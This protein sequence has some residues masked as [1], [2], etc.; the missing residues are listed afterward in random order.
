MAL[1]CNRVER[2]PIQ[3]FMRSDTWG[4]SPGGGMIEQG[5]YDH[6]MPKFTILLYEI[7]TIVDKNGQVF[8]KVVDTW[9]YDEATRAPLK[10]VK[11]TY[12]LV[13]LPRV[14]HRASLVKVQLDDTVYL[15]EGFIIGNADTMSER[16]T[17][18]GYVIYDQL[19]T[20]MELTADQ[21]AA[22]HEKGIEALPKGY[23]LSI[24]RQLIPDSAKDWHSAT[25]NAAVVQKT[26][27][28]QITLWRDPI[29][30][31]EKR[32]TED[33]QKI[34]TITMKKDC[35]R[36]T[37]P[38]F[39]RSEKLKDPM[40]L[41]F[42]IAIDA[43]EFEAKS[44]AALGVKCEMRKGGCKLETVDRFGATMVQRVKPQKYVVYRKTV[45]L[46]NRA[47]ST[48]QFGIWLT[49]PGGEKGIGIEN[50]AVKDYTGAT[51]S[52]LPA[53]VSYTEPDDPSPKP[54]YGWE[55]VGETEPV[56]TQTDLDPHGTLYDGTVEDGGVYEY[57]AL[58][59]VGTSES[60]E[61]PHRTVTYSGPLTNTSGVQ[62]KVI[63]PDDGPAAVVDIT[64]PVLDGVPDGYG[65]TV[66]IMLPVAPTSV[67]DLKQIGE[68]VGVRQMLQNGDRYNVRVFPS[69][70]FV[71]LERGQF[72]QLPPLTVE[73]WGAGLHLT[74]QV[75]PETLVVEGFGF[76]ARVTDGPHFEC[77]PDP[78][79][80]EI[81]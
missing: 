25:N 46:P 29:K 58:A 50:T 34:V 36:D 23:S 77:A 55:Q 21:L 44:A 4:Q 11:E 9:Q 48:N 17:T 54:R 63:T 51:V 15:A 6:K 59:V 13:Y 37:P 14:N 24:E 79:E 49:D 60:P 28:P 26:T 66:T 43:P 78:I 32:V 33:W 40:S 61:S 12:A 67:E 19:K 27:A 31:E 39:T 64:G 10:H 3:D 1:I 68:D 75:V 53:A 80:L 35:L 38:D 62:V 8:S 70:P 18:S 41:E 2:I 56:V 71:T 81:P 47:A 45:S 76:E 72:M 20:V 57:Y 74:T 30:I 5:Y 7:K 65:E 69:V 22:V 73:T 16:T 42:P 52:P